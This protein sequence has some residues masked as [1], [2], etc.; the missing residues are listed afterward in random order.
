[1]K[2]SSNRRRTKQE[3]KEAQAAALAKEQAI[4]EKLAAI[5]SLHDE[6]ELFKS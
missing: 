1:M 6:L 3:I 4:Q 5:E 2:A